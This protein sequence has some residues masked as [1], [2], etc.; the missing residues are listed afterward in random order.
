MALYCFFLKAAH[1]VRWVFFPESFQLCIFLENIIWY[2][3]FVKLESD[4]IYC[5]L[6]QMPYPKFFLW[7]VSIQNLITYLLCSTSIYYISHFSYEINTL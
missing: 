6:N 5:V 3:D 1:Y 2:K 7:A 4:E